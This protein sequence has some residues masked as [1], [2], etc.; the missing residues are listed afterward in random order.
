MLWF[1]TLLKRDYH[2][3]VSDM[4]EIV[5]IFSVFFTDVVS[6]NDEL[7]QPRSMSKSL[8]YKDGV[9]DFLEDMKNPNPN[10]LGLVDIQLE[11][12]SRSDSF[13]ESSMHKSSKQILSIFDR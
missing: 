5:R 2:Y 8:S 12:E 1:Y 11:I 6:N 9:L 7:N 3:N 10:D 13:D 4:S